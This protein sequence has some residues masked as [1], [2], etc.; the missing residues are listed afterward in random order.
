MNYT[1]GLLTKVSC[2]DTD[3]NYSYDKWG[4]TTKVE[5]AGATYATAETSDDELTNT[6]FW[7]SGDEF[8]TET[9][10]YGKT[11]MQ[12]AK[13]NNGIQEKVVNEYDPETS[14][15]NKT[16]IDINGAEA[17]NIGYKYD[18]VDGK[19]LSSVR[20]GEYALVKQNGYTADGE[21]ESTTYKLAEQELSIL[22]KRTTLPTSVTVTLFYPST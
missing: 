3:Y 11:V 19:L 2:G 5:I 7:A 13:Y 16:T 10:K 21:V 15:L 9:D 18:E 12:A 17:Y 14:R 4:R 1:V 20:S 6:T 8:V 22:T